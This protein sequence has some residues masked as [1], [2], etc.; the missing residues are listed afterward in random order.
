MNESECRWHCWGCDRGGDAV[1]LVAANERLGV[2]DAIRRTEELFG[3]GDGGSRE[4]SDGA[5]GGLFPRAPRNNL[6]GG[7]KKPP[8]LSL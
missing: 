2:A 6:R 8:W 1:D 4:E 5:G 7:Y 3:A